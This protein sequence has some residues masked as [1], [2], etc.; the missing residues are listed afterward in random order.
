MA[1][2]IRHGPTYER[3]LQRVAVGPKTKQVL[4]DI[5]KGISAAAGENP[6]YPDQS[7]ASRRL[8]KNT[9]EVYKVR[10]PDLDRNTGKRGGYRLVYPW[11]RTEN[12]LAGLFFY[13]KSEKEDVTQHEI[14]AARKRLAS[15]L[16]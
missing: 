15:M 9:S 10:V 3:D 2:V 16:P 13:H 14:D 7:R 4:D 1:I 6:A 8:K 11:L 5:W 12:R